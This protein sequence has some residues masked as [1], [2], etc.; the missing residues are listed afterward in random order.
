MQSLLRFTRAIHSLR[1]G[2]DSVSK[3]LRDST[4]RNIKKAIAEGVE[5]EGLDLPHLNH[6]SQLNKQT[7]CYGF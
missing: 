5:I 7:E 6:R 2:G 3:R 4:M 1:K